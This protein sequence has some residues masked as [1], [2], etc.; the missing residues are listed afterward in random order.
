MEWLV[1]RNKAQM[2]EIWLFEAARA[3]GSATAAKAPRGLGGLPKEKC[4]LEVP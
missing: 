3:L 1:V 4:I 2:R